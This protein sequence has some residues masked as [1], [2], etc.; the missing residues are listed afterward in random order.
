MPLQAVK[1]PPNP[2]HQHFVEYLGGEAEPPLARLRVM[3]DSSRSVLARNDSP[4]L[5]FRYSLNPYRGCLHGCAYCYARPTHEQ[6]GLG[7]GTD[8]ERVIVVKPEAPRLL[9]EAFDKPSWKGER[10]LFSGN[11]DCYQALEASYGLTRQCLEVC[12]EYQNPVSIIT[13]SPL[14]ERDLDVLERLHRVTRLQVL[15]S[16]PFID[17]VHARAIEP[18]VA[19]PERRFR[20]IEA[21]SKAGIAVAVNVAPVIPGL[22][23]DQI[24]KVLRAAAEAGASGAAYILLR[25]PGSVKEI[26]SQALTERLPLKAESV[27]RRTREVRA[28]RLNDPRFHHRQR[29][30]GPYA[31]AIQRLFTS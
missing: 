27:V 30:N 10:I 17:P 18:Y 22:N 5:G 28:G 1:N 19:L 11:T 4:D 24:G 3:T 8:F 9:R 14:I 16:V 25:L 15:I 12:A 6:L 26:F 13:K 23:D 7:A 21:L 2:Y 31:A 29:G 20:T